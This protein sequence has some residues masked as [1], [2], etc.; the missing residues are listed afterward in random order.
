MDPLVN[1]LFFLI[2]GILLII[3]LLFFVV[4]IVYGAP[5][6]PTNRESLRKM[7]KFAKVKKGDKVVDLGSG[8]GKIVI[9]FAKLDNVKESHG[10]EINPLL[11]FSSRRRIR[12]LKLE[13]K[14]FIHW[15]DFWNQ[16][17][18]DYDVVNVF[19][20]GFIMKNLEKKLKKELKKNSRIISN[21]WKF[22]NLK[23]RKQEGDIYLYRL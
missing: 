17:L 18:S 21:T 3:F 11:V 2:S 8:N 5:F 12:Q 15:K 1:M 6:E 9:E 20:I 10:F 16:N 22:S 14:A 13:K 23:L 7:I 19:Q 4:P